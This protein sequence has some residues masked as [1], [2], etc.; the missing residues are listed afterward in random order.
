MNNIKKYYILIIYTLFFLSIFN[1]ANSKNFE[2]YNNAEK[3]SNY[4]SGILRLNNNDYLGSYKKF[5]QLEGLEDNHYIYSRVYQY[6]LINLE[7]FD[8]AYQYSKK[9]KRKN[10]SNFESDLISGVFYLKNK[11]FNLALDSFKSLKKNK[12]QNPIQKLLSINLENWLAIKDID[13]KEDALAIILAKESQFKNFNKIQEAFIHC[14]YRSNET[15]KKFKNLVADSKS[16]FSRY[17][18]FHANYL[19][20]NG[21]I[22]NAKNIVKKTINIENQNL[23]LNQLQLDM[24]TKKYKNFSNKFDCKKLS[25]IVAELFYIIANVSSSNSMY[26]ISNFYL[27]LA[28]YLNPDFISFERLYAE[29]FFAINDLNNAKKLYLKI[30]KSGSFYSWYSAKQNVKI[31]LRQNKKKEAQSYL[32][33][34]FIKIVNPSIYEIYDYAY[35]LKDNKKYKKS[36]IYYT[37]ILKLINNKHKLYTSTT[38]GRGISYERIDNWKMAEKD[39]LDSLAANPNQAYVINYLAYSWIEKGINIDK[40]LQMLRK[41]NEL[42]KDDAYIIDSLGWALFKLKKF[43]EANKYLNLAVTYLPTDPVIGDHYADSLWM[44]NKTLQA[45]YYWNHV[46]S[47]KEIDDKLK[48]LIEKKII[49]GLSQLKS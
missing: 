36:I 39:F 26:S 38:Y 37:K 22:E 42:K 25:N 29:N 10:I 41:A 46:L 3:I 44:N 49:F 40:S 13:N 35:F 47:L 24:Q 28:K 19:Y 4:F 8:E 7:R 43:K 48:N 14:Y 11:K 2:K 5:K 9:L 21:K 16:D 20:K 32:D 33:K 1:F 30:S 15:S 12:N 23:I 6:N 18:F 17:N 45:R 31:F 34:T 27:N